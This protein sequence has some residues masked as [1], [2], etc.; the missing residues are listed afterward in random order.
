M[1]ME[2]QQF[3]DVSP[4]KNADVPLPVLVFGRVAPAQKIKKCPPRT[5]IKVYLG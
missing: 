4:T 3:E 1:T 2:N 5:L